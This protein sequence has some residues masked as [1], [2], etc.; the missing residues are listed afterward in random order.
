MLSILVENFSAVHIESWHDQTV[1]L[2]TTN[3]QFCT[4]TPNSSFVQ[5]S[6]FNYLFQFLRLLHSK[7]IAQV[8]TAAVQNELINMVFNNG[9]FF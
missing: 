2:T 4:G 8:T 7:N 5:R 6:D 1:S 9:A 3:N